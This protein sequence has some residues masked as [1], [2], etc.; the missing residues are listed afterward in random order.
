MFDKEEL[1]VIGEI[2]KPGVAEILKGFCVPI[3]VQLTAAKARDETI[4]PAW[5]R[6]VVKKRFG[7]EERAK[8][9]NGGGKPKG[10]KEITLSLGLDRKRI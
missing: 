3:G 7:K 6:H 10:A 1:A 8:L 9:G 5:K 2:G 4:V